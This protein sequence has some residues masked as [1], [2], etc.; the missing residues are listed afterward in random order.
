MATGFQVLGV[1]PKIQFVNEAG[2]PVYMLEDG[3]P[4][5]ELV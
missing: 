3:R 4:I 2:R 1:D 5:R